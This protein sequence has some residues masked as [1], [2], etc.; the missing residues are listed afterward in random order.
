[1]ETVNVVLECLCIMEKESIIPGAPLASLAMRYST[2]RFRAT[3]L[4]LQI[5][6]ASVITIIWY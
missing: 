5:F 3:A 4:V 1:M 2:W 6:N